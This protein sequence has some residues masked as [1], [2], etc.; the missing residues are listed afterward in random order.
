MST[1]DPATV[2]ATAPVSPPA[3]LSPANPLAGP[4]TLPYALPPFAATTL[5]HCREALLAGMAEQRAEVAAL[6]AD[7]AEPTFENTIVALERS[8]QLLGR[9]EHV[10]VADREALLRRHRSHAK[11]GGSRHAQLQAHP[12][13]DLVHRQS[14][15][16]MRIARPPTGAPARVAAIA[17]EA[18]R[19]HRARP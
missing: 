11:P 18:A 10:V 3:T 4:S 9:A 15:E 16:V 19:R 14:P 7:P 8:G 2:P 13:S 12:A 1:A 6:A 5:E 17:P